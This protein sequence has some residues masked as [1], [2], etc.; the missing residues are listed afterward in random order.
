[1]NNLRPKQA[2]AILRA[3]ENRAIQLISS[4]LFFLMLALFSMQALAAAEKAIVCK[5]AYALC[6]AAKCIPDPR[7]S[8]HAICNCDNYD[9]LSAGTVSCDARKPSIDDMGVNHLVST[10]SFENDALEGMTCPSGSVWANCVNA[11]CSVDPTDPKKSICS[12]PL[13]DKGETLVFGAKCNKHT[14]DNYYWSAA[15]T[16]SHNF[17][18]DALAKEA[19]KPKPTFKMCQ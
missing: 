16:S 8:T 4:L 6:S 2:Q 11:P 15:L 3:K 1:M 19:G 9:G 7:D 5:Q 14:C 18:G 12:C 17:L 13:V 10:F